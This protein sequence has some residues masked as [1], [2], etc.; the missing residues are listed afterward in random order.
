LRIQ[1][2]DVDKCPL[3]SLDGGNKT[4]K[5]PKKTIVSTAVLAACLCAAAAA[6]TG[7]AFTYQGHLYDD[8]YAANGAFDFRFRLYAGESD[9]DQVGS[10]VVR[11]S[12]EVVDG[13]FAA[14]LDFGGVF[15]GTD[16]WLEIGVRAGDLED[17]NEYTPLSPRQKVTASPYALFAL[18][19]N[20]G[21]PGPMGPQGPQGDTGPIGPMGPQGPQGDTGPPGPAGPKGDTGPQGPAGPE[22]PQGPVGPEGPPGPAGDSHWGLSGSDTYYDAGS[23]GIGTSDPAGNRLK[24]AGD[25]AVTGTLAAAVIGNSVIAGGGAN[26]WPFSSFETGSAGIAGGSSAGSGRT[27]LAAR[28]GSYSF[29]VCGPGHLGYA[30]IDLATGTDLAAYRDYTVSSHVASD[31]GIVGQVSV[32]THSPEGRV[33]VGET[34]GSGAWER[35][36]YTFTPDRDV[37]A[38]S[39]LLTFTVKG[40]A[41]GCIYIDDIMLTEGS[42]LAAFAPNQNEVVGDL[43]VGGYLIAHNNIRLNN[44]YLSG[45]G[46]SEGVFVDAEGN[47]AIGTDAPAGLFHVMALDERLDQHNPGS[48]SAG[49]GA[50]NQWQSFTAAMTGS[51]TKISVSLS[52]NCSSPLYIR[53]GEGTSGPILSTTTV[54]VPAGWQTI[55]ISDCGVTAGQVYT[56]NF[57]NWT[58]W[59]YSVGD[60]YT[61]GTCSRHP[62]QDFFFWTYV[63]NRSA[64]F[65]VTSL[66]GD[67][68][69]GTQSPARKLH[70]A[71]VMRLEPR[72]TAPSDA[73]EGDMYM[74]GAT[75]RLMVYDG[76]DW[77]ACW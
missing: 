13:Y 40:N 10:D 76:T 36:S 69:V 56:I 45:D 47:T 58:A 26:L 68:G 50:S 62:D 59:H 14:E 30:D 3:L 25:A 18:A 72:D 20:E 63:T 49:G 75:H 31:A 35:L 74:D 17:P 42:V 64:P 77:Q 6:E 38:G 43:K 16:R 8:Y 48:V 2:A 24:V 51:L 57:L 23:V 71:D 1:A 22:G 61:G 70:V 53:E 27:T 65:V 39:Q 5:S 15:D 21:P 12:V 28:T 46:D 54:D 67:V 19:G 41:A 9:P 60:A 7:T 32:T 11:D 73:A 66:G 29:K 37:A 33:V 52:G 44:R 34:T 55:D 4:M